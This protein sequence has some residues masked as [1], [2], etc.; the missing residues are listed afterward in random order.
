VRHDERER[1]AAEA[2]ERVRRDT[3]TVGSSS[4]ARVARRVGD[5]FAGHDA[6][7][8]GEGGATDPMEVW[9]RRIG[10]VLSGVLLVGLTW[11]LGVQLGW[12]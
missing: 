2:L 4:L 8:A 9:G 5:H 12:W 6:I 11:W 7:G 10:R 1:A 3:E